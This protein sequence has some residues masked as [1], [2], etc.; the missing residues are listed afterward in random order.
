MNRLSY[1]H[2]RRIKNFNKSDEPPTYLRQVRRD[3]PEGLIF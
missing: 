3:K 2:K 1:D